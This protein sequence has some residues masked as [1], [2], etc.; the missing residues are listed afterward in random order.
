MQCISN[1][2]LTSTAGALLVL[3]VVDVRYVG[4]L[5]IRIWIGNLTNQLVDSS[6]NSITE[7]LI[8]SKKTTEFTTLVQFSPIQPNTTPY[9]PK[10]G[11]SL[12]NS[13]NVFVSSFLVIIVQYMKW[14]EIKYDYFPKYGFKRMK[15]FK[16][17][18][19]LSLQSSV[20]SI[21]CILSILFLSFWA[22]IKPIMQGTKSFPI[23]TKFAKSV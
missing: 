4:L 17:T 11:D 23:L 13:C 19:G 7:L 16:S 10:T 9:S 15:M 18:W 14:N 6:S 22:Q 20:L 2:F 12:R 1:L 5:D 3:N 21:S 8:D